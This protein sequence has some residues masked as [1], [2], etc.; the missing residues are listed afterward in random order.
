[1]ISVDKI[2]KELAKGV[3]GYLRLRRIVKLHPI[4][5]SVLLLLFRPPGCLLGVYGCGSRFLGS[6]VVIF[7]FPEVRVGLETGK[8]MM[9]RS[10]KYET[11][12]LGKIQRREIRIS[13]LLAPG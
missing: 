11:T 3:K 12:R 9:K 10:G 8:N 6:L 5:S 2:I 7:N 13:L 1:M 4:F